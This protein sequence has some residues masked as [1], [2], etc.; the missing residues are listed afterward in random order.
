MLVYRETVPSMVVVVWI[1][2]LCTLNEFSFPFQ[3][4]PWNKTGTE[5][6]TEPNFCSY[7][8]RTHAHSVV[9]IPTCF[10][11]HSPPHLHPSLPVYVAAAV[12]TL[13]F[14]WKVKAF[15]ECKVDSFVA[16]STC[17]QHTEVAYLNTVGNNQWPFITKHCSKNFSKLGDKTLSTAD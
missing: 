15:S 12:K 3:W 8:S 7:C 6:G 17:L 4:V 10:S 1:D 14:L 2:V 9:M 13:V 5:P 11:C 16:M